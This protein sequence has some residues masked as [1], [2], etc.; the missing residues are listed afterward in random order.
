[1]KSKDTLEWSTF[2]NYGDRKK[3]GRLSVLVDVKSG[4]VHPVPKD[5]EHIDFAR[6]L[7]ITLEQ[8]VPSHIDIEQESINIITGVCGMEIGFG[9]RHKRKDLETAHE[10]ILEYI[11][12]GEIRYQHLGWKIIYRYVAHHEK[13]V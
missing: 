6:S 3:Q 7:G 11:S 9:I 10:R 12:N 5:K 1:M 8:L 13:R 2:N 4:N